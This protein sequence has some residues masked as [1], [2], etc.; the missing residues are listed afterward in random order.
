MWFFS[1]LFLFVTDTLHQRLRDD[2]LSPDNSYCE[3]EVFEVNLEKQKPYGIGIT[4]VGGDSSSKQDVGLFVK[5]VTKDGSAFQDGRIKPGDRIIAINNESVDGKE[6]HEAVKIIKHSKGKVKLLI[7]QIKPPGSI[8]KRDYD[9]TLFEMKLHESI[10]EHEKDHM[11][12]SSSRNDIDHSTVPMITVCNPSVHSSHEKD[13]KNNK[14][15]ENGY[16]ENDKNTAD[17]HSSIPKMVDELEDQDVEN[18]TTAD[19]HSTLSLVDSL[20]SEI[21]ASD[22]AADTIN[23]WLI[24][25]YISF[26]HVNYE[27]FTK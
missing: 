23:G 21:A 16:I 1:S 9:D 24:L 22:I 26:L 10:L 17:A 25:P 12:L 11:D 14:N 15:I 8:K 4:I 20:H 7:S 13:K 18:S 6:H 2:L 19:V 3:K 5:S 27:L